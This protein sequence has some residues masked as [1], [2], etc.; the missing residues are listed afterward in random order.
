[1]KIFLAGQNG[2]HLILQNIIGGGFDNPNLDENIFSRGRPL[3]RWG[4]YDPIIKEHKPY[5]LESFYYVD[6]TTEKLLPY[7]GDFLL[8]SGAFTFMSNTHTSEPDWDNYIQR[9]ADFINRNKVDKFFELDIDVLVGYDKVKDYRKKLENLTDKQ[10]I[11][12]W[13]KSR[14]LDEFYKLC[15]D[16]S[17]IAIGGIVTKE[18][19]REQYPMFSKLIKIAHI[20]NCKIHGLGFSNLERIKKYH[21]DSVD[22]TTWTIG[23][24]YGYIYQF[25][26]KTMQRATVPPGKRLKNPKTIALINYTEWVKFQKWAEVNL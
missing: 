16:Y 19:T 14:G 5:I 12:V 17:Y 4:G 23:N 22:S 13:H 8:D 24:R 20:N 15:E 9:Y 6:N 7:F 18:I 11:P 1:M 26:G 25:D 10:C 2:L 3:E 21:F